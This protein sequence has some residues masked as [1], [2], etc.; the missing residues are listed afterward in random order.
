[1][2]TS[3]WHL[4]MVASLTC[5]TAMAAARATASPD[6]GVGS[7]ASTR[8]RPGNAQHGFDPRW[9]QVSSPAPG[10]P[11]SIGQPGAGC[12]QGAAAL[13]GHARDYV[14]AHPERQR[15]FGHPDLVA[16]LREVAKAA[17]QQKLG[18]L[19]IG[20]L[21]QPRG[22]PTPTGHRS[23][24]NGLDV[25]LWYGPPAKAS[26]GKAPTPPSVVDLR[27][28]K[29]LPAWTARAARLLA[30]AASRPTVDR[31]FVHPAVKR[32][33]CQD[34]PKVKLDPK[35]PKDPKDKSERGDWLGRLRPWWGHQDH[36]HVRLRCPTGSPE[37]TASPPLPA[38]DGCG[39]SLDWWFSAD[40]QKTAAKRAA[41]G[42]GAPALPEACEALLGQKR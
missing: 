36:F 26:A 3:T 22:G 39:A 8:P 13:P 1:M 9:S 11:L 21:G 25:D 2:T 24:Q 19:Y 23:H 31:I 4:L 15:Q 18:P 42:E 38:G 32:A 34:N 16:Y 29:M 10:A 33:L 12:L 20:D 17:H 6:G 28:K 41:P 5:F 40:A 37:C 30:L 7:D 14:L 27:T 35:D